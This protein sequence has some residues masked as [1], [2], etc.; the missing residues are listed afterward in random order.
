MAAA[1]PR[2]R[3]TFFE[4]FPQLF[5]FPLVI[6]TVCV[7]VWLFFVASSQDNR[8]VDELIT[9]IQSG[10]AHGRKQDAYSLAL[11]ARE[12]AADGKHFSPG[13]TRQLISFLQRERRLDEDSELLEFL[14]MAVGRAGDPSLS[15]PLMSEIAVS[16]TDRPQAAVWAVRAL[17]LS[18][19]SE[20]AVTL[21]EVIAK[22]SQPDD[23]E[24]RWNALAGLT[25]LRDPA[26]V[27]LLEETL[28]ERR[29]E[30]RWSA[31]CW[32]ASVFSSD[33][34]RRVLSS[35][36]EWDFL[37]EQIGEHGQGLTFEQKEKYMLMALEGLVR[38]DGRGT[39]ELL[40]RKSQE[41]R[42]LQVRNLALERIEELEASDA[43]AS[44]GSSDRTQSSG[45][46]G[47]QITSQAT[48]G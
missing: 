40:R 42:S 10:G 47:V 36:V 11:K 38:L 33:A 9:D 19:S 30:L 48:S 45:A 23:W 6:V 29:R 16:E 17:G 41:K 46:V 27:P 22:R 39:L 13:N 44:S 7:L 1:E 34:G 32:L 28:N 3:K 5:L 2:S 4:L 18:G 15:V 14:V 12:F 20:A 26:V 24:F 21:R 43:E 37:D 31:A 8:S 25:N 35:L